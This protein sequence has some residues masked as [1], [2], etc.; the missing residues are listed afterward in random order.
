MRTFHNQTIETNAPEETAKLAGRLVR[1][2]TKLPCLVL[3]KGPLGAGKTQFVKGFVR[4]Y[5]G[6]KTPVTSPT[7]SIV[8]AY[9]VGKKKVYHV[10]LHRL[11][12][13]D[14]LESV[15][16]WDFFE[17]KSVILVEWGEMLPPSWPKNSSVWQIDFEII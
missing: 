7:Y 10:D 3:L 14:D 17:E 15:G 6:L 1:E 16:F 8:N 12:S 5:L 13:A 4:S 2:I 9:Q 11:K